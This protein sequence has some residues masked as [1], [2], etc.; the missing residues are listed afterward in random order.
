MAKVKPLV[1][2]SKG[3]LDSKLAFMEN[4]SMAPNAATGSIVDPNANVSQKN[5]ATMHSELHKDINIQ[6]NRQLMY[7]KITELFNETLAKE[8]IRQLEDHEI[9]KHK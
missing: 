3:Q 6:I 5:I 2:L 7:D 8:Y 1:R 4:Y 9:Y